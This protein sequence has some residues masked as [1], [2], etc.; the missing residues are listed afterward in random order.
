M[1]RVPKNQNKRKQ[2]QLY[3]HV[4]RSYQTL[5]THYVF[6]IVK[7]NFIHKDNFDFLGMT[8]YFQRLL[9]VGWLVCLF[10]LEESAKAY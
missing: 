2:D 3:S 8:F 5:E 4:P 1:Y 9:A 10:A 6:D 7:E